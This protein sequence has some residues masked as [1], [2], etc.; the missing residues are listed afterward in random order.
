MLMKIVA[1]RS[2]L[3]PKYT[4]FVQKTHK[5]FEKLVPFSPGIPEQKSPGTGI[6]EPSDP[7]GSPGTN[8]P[9]PSP[10]QDSTPINS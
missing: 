10:I 4:D 5:I 8:S 2:Y 9:G 3:K 1:F 6:L 7:R